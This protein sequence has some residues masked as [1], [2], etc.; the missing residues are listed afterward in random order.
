MKVRIRGAVMLPPLLLVVAA[1]V[2]AQQCPDAAGLASGVAPILAPVRVLADDAYGGRM[3]GTAG[4]RCAGDYIAARFAAIG[5]EPAGTDGYFQDVPLASILNPHA[6]GATGRN[7]LAL[8]PGSDPSLRDEIVVIGAHYDHLGHGGSGSL[9]PGDS[10]IHN[11]AD[12]NA[13][14]VAAMLAAAVRLASEP[15]SRSILFMAFTGEESGLLGS[16]H[17][18]S[19]PTR[20]LA[21]VRA[22]LNMDMVGRLEDGPLI[23]YG[24]GTAE[25]WP[26]ILDDAGA[27]VGI[28]LTYQS[29]GYGPSDHTSFYSHDIPV[30]HFF[31]NTHADYHK[32]S[33]DWQKIDVDGLQRVSI[34]VSRV[35][36]AVADRPADL[37][38]VRGAGQPNDPA[39][40][41]SGHGAWLGT[42]PDFAPVERGVRLGGVTPGSPADEAGLITGDILIGMAGEEISDLQAMQDVLD[43]HRPGETIDLVVLRDG[44]EVRARATLGNRNR[45]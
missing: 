40:S 23:V 11:G 6:V 4:E 45:R 16:A 14:G 12:D 29:E 41:G 18:V 37:A 36:R 35:A 13:S 2:A 21:D 15:P 34:L 1:P 33:D 31:S 28:D 20:S 8:L 22:M 43:A 30:L 38:L 27:A 9:T 19:A 7:V 5:L 10:S 25:E 39:A 42:V 44:A 24:T 3:A 17:W 26:A 32:P